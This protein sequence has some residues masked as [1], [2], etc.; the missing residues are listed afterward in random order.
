M[1]LCWWVLGQ[2]DRGK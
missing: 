1:F 2:G